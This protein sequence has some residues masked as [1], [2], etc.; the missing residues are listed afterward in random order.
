LWFEALAGIC[1]HVRRGGGGL[2]PT[3]I[4]PARLSQQQIDELEGHYRVADVL[5]L[6]PLQQGLLFHANAAHGL[7]DDVYAVQLDITLNGPLD[8]HRLR[9][10]VHTVVTR[11][12]NVAARFCERFGEPV[13][14]IPADPETPW[15]YVDLSAGVIDI[16]EHIQQLS[17]AER[18]AVCNL[19][20]QPAFRVAAIRTAPDRHRL[21][22]TNHHILMDGWSLQILLRE[23]FASYIGHRLPA[24]ESYRRFVSWLAGRDLGAAQAAWREV[25]AGFDIPTLVGPPDRIGVGPRDVKSFRVPEE[26][27]RALGELARS[28]HTTVS[29]VLQAAFAQLLC[30]LTGQHDVAFGAVVSGR[31]A[32]VTGA[33]SMVGLMI[34]TVPVRA[35]ITPTTTTT[36]LL[37]QLQNAHNHTLEHQHLAL[38][39]I[40]RI[41]G[42]ERL[43]DT[44]FVYEN[45]PT[46]TARLERVDELVITESNDRDYY[47]YP[48]TIQAAPGR[49][50][51]LRLQFRTDVFDAATVEELIE[52][53]KRVLVAMTSDPTRRLSTGALLE[54]RGREAQPT[55]ADSAL[56][57]QDTGDGDRA[58][59]SLVE[60]ILA[61]IYAHVLGV[62]RVGVDESFFDLGGNS[63]SAMRAIAAINTAFDIN[64]AV[65][66][67]FDASSVR[68]LSQQLADTSK[69]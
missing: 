19:A 55:T 17:A 16:E 3:D 11:H 21:V 25:L 33:D 42:Q 18:T 50:L 22:L 14:I 30:S 49:E 39:D 56:E 1:A 36:D 46:G 5:P 61:G 34:N 44:V 68:S 48:L 58:P 29:N 37:E 52:Q 31:P 27:T 12:P 67:F 65:N 9:D 47:H 60:R 10:A 66:T 62:D 8:P 2:T 32:E 7:G 40:H 53:F 20:E 28:H 38:S 54:G 45:Y 63:L 69:P 26:T 4:A 43:F 41:V 57:H 15:R 59:A 35:N 51:G 24:A 6:T 23:I 64:L 13:Q